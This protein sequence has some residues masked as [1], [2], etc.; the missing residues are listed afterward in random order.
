MHGTR[1]AQSGTAAKLGSGHAQFVTD[2]PQE[3][4]VWFGVGADGF[5]VDLK[6]DAHGGSPKKG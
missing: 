6:L 1:T 4:G 2:D 5:A 3:R